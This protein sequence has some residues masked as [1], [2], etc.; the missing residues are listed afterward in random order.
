MTIPKINKL[1]FACA[2]ACAPAVLLGAVD[3]ANPALNPVKLDAAPEHPPLELVVAGQ[4]RFVLVLDGNAESRLA[5]SA[6]KSIEPAVAALQANIAKATGT[7]PK[8]VDVSEVD[9][10][11]D[12]LRILVGKSALTDALGIDIA[13][14]P[15]EGFVVRSF[16]GGIAIVGND[17]SVDPAFNKKGPLYDKGARKATL[18]GAYDFIERFFGA[19]FY[20]PGADGSVH[21]PVDNLVVQPFAY[22]DA[23]RF[24]NRG[25]FYMQFPLEGTEKALGVKLAPRDL[26]DF[27]GAV[28]WA[29][30]EPFTSMHSPYPDQWAKANPEKIESSFF[31]NQQGRLYYS[32]TAH[33]ANYF[34]VTNLKFADNLI[35]SLKRY[36]ES[37]GKERQGFAYNNGYYIV[38]GQADNELQLDELK[39]NPT[40]E[41][42]GLITEANLALGR[43]GYFSDIY[44]RF[45]KYLAE[46]VK[47]EFPGKKLIVMPYASYAFA[48]TQEK[49][50]L[51]DNVELGVCLGRIPRFIRNEQVRS[52][53]TEQL[54]RWHEALGKRPVQQLWT[55]NAGNNCFVHAI[56]TELMGETIRA[57]DPYVG[58]VEI[59]HEFGMWPSP[60]PGETIACNFYYATYVGMRA[61]WNPGFDADAAI[62]EHWDAFY[63]P[64]AG[65]HL[66][67]AHSILKEAY[68]KYASPQINPKP[69][70]PVTVLDDLERELDAA[71]KLLRKDSVEYRRYLVMAKPLRYELKS[72]RGQHAYNIPLYPVK[73]VPSGE[74][75]VTDGKGGEAVWCTAKPVPLIDPRGTGDAPGFPPALRLVWT[76]E[77]L[78]GF[79]DMPH[80]PKAD[81]KDMW[82]NDVAE[83]FLS[84]G[85]EQEM[86][87]Q[88]S[89]DPNS[90][91]QMMKRVMK[92]FMMPMNHA[93]T[94]EG[95]AF[96]T[97]SR[98]D[99]WSYEF[100]I[101]YAGLEVAPPKAYDSWK[102]GFV[103]NKM[104]EPQ[105]VSANAMTL[106][107]NHNIAAHGV[108]KF[109]GKGD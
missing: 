69:L 102:F 8:I 58:D 61:F 86:Y 71:E 39:S 25:T 32:A 19:R 50:H 26:E 22:S 80:R 89:V 47:T 56:A 54:R 51:P 35:D 73:R 21:P 106:G 13:A 109:L 98:A 64:E 68:F 88:I 72:Q 104:G 4:P 30:T 108:I 101:P 6:W 100:F 85:L 41:A 24:K 7:A 97:D 53:Y 70:Y 29:K 107:N 79:M 3:L 2:C 31:R 103:Y 74:I 10:Y 28:R 46:R 62:A 15:P 82:M 63:G 48:P 94:C 83:I 36:Y 16:S 38:F 49:Y 75:I 5:H 23:P 67:K 14:F 52:D 40:V 84:P 96:A 33:A 55:Y 17:S 57:L 87:V 43:D 9:D 92:P 91:T 59:F 99:G 105:E 12:A 66:E 18:W 77:G 44:A 93:W 95:F 60:F 20:Y 1:A 34:D 65:A 11:P 37:D 90:R 27:L 76:D 42:E 81:A 45:Y 78:H